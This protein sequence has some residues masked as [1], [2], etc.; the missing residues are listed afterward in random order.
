MKYAIDWDVVESKGATPTVQLWYPRLEGHAQE[1]EI[2]LSDV[3]AADSVRVRYDFERDGWVILQ[4]STFEWSCDDP[5]CDSDWQEV[6]FIKSWNR[7]KKS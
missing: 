7:E 5:I 2:E 3:R 6:A 1:I 4:A